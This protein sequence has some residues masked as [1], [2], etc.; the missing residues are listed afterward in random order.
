ML[1]ALA[2]AHAADGRLDP[3]VRPTAQS[4]QLTLDPAADGYTGT[5]TITL[6]VP[7]RTQS[8][9]L[10]SEDLDV[11]AVRVGQGKLGEATFTVRGSR[12]TITSPRV[13]KPGEAVVELDFANDYRTDL[14]GLYKTT[15][16]DRPYL[17][18]QF[19]ADD[20]RTAFP[21]FD[22]PSFK[23]PWTVELITPPGLTTLANQPV[24]ETRPVA[25]G[26]LHRFSPSPPMPSYL[27]AL[28]VGPFD[29]VPVEAAVP[30]TV[31]SPAGTASHT[32][33]LVRQIPRHHDVLADWFGSPLPYDKLDFVVVPE[34]AYG[35]M[36][37]VGLVTVSD[38]L[39][40]DP[41]TATASQRSWVGEVTAHEIA[42]MWFGNL[43]TMAWWDDLWLNESFASW[44]GLKA[45]D[46]VLGDHP[47]RQARVWRAFDAMALDGRA[48]M[49]PVRTEVD[50]EHVFET[51]NNLAYP[52][53]QAVL[54]MT[55][56][57]MGTAAFQQGLRAYM[58]AHRFGNAR[59]A[60]LFQAL[61]DA[62]GVD[63]GSLL[64]PY[65][66]VPGAPLLVFE[67]T[68]TGFAVT[69][70]RYATLG[71]TV[72]STTRWTV[73]LVGR[74]A[75]GEVRAMLEGDGVVET[76]DGWFLPM[77]A[78]VGYFG[79]DFADPADLDALVAAAE[80]LTP[81]E[82]TALVMNL[83]NLTA[84]G[85]LDLGRMLAL[86]TQLV[87]V[88]HPSVERSMLYELGTAEEVVDAELEEAFA[89]WLRDAWGPRLDHYGLD[90]ADD[91]PTQ[92]T[93]TRRKLLDWLGEHGRHPQV[94]ALWATRV[95][96]FLA[97]PGSASPRDVRRPFLAF[98]ATQDAS[99]QAR[100]LERAV[101]TDDPELRRLYLLAFGSVDGEDAR[102]RA[103]AW[104]LEDGRTFEDTFV[105]MGAVYDDADLHGDEALQW[106]I[107]HWS[108]L[109]DR[110]PVQYHALM[111][112]MGGGCSEARFE[113]A[114]TFFT[115]LSPQP[116]GLDR[117]LAETAEAV[118]ACI[119]RRETHRPAL[120][121]F[122]ADQTGR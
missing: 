39:L 38:R 116:A 54:S 31:Y 120:A 84:A 74:N 73:P 27:V 18:T 64:Q 69:Q 108:I 43:V 48:A 89:R 24:V 42:H 7:E 44:M 34:H 87:G 106:T 20:A 93:Q 25:D 105:V 91:E 40:L 82:Q 5:T 62:S 41:D 9:Q 85:R 100:M 112:G 66:D 113:R 61:S 17:V 79:W 10:H 83:R 14:A 65:L 88:V 28:A 35:G 37:N 13:L 52:K 94:L 45:S 22:E 118:Q 119:Q 53:G 71:S 95:E 21:C 1:L 107:D 86:Y 115:S 4:V 51:T 78:G 102:T 29:A 49:L 80:V 57:W 16:K 32:A 11:S 2:L 110:I 114:R 67:R 98:A 6:D 60:D 99:F 23:I 50:P 90:A 75:T 101:A 117:R 46:A 81:A 122:L 19:E 121:A 8:F 59:A 36:E 72:E 33:E 68:P 63:V 96:A 30:S 58:D 92:V 104:A 97:D 15:E 103:L 109:R 26:V 55:E 12:L 77:A 111:V 47:N 56:Q 3:P 76:G 70:S